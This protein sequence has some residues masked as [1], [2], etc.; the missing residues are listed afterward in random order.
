MYCIAGGVHDQELRENHSSNPQRETNEERQKKKRTEKR[1]L[2]Q[3]KYQS[4]VEQLGQQRGAWQNEY[5]P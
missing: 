5:W 3:N 2:K 1:V 4:E